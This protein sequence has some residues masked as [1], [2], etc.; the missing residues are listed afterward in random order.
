MD[1][2]LLIWGTNGQNPLDQRIGSNSIRKANPERPNV[3][4]GLPTVGHGLPT[5]GHGLPTVGHG[6][7]TKG[8]PLWAGRGLQRKMSGFSFHEGVRLLGRY[9]LLFNRLGVARAVL[10]QPRH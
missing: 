10:K 7:P 5:V 1:Y 8:C 9:V 2:F 4:R 3:G 6:L